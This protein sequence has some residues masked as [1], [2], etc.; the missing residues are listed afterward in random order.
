MES[1]NKDI[2]TAYSEALVEIGHAGPEFAFDNEGPKRFQTGPLIW[3]WL[4]RVCRQLPL[5]WPWWGR[6]PSTTVL[7]YSRCTGESI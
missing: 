1:S 2:T 3:V 6:S 4:N 5:G 7:P